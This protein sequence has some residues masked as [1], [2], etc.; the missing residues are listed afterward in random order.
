MNRRLLIAGPVLAFLLAG[1]A[2][3][4][5]VGATPVSISINA[6]NPVS[7][8]EITA[9]AQEHCQQYGAHARRSLE[10]HKPTNRT[11]TFDCVP[12]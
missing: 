12:E 4:D 10:S 11:I 8:A 5:V 6:T 3:M 7:D 2:R 1:C 9:V